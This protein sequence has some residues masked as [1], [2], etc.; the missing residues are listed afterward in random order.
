MTKAGY[1]EP[2]MSRADFSNFV[3]TIMVWNS[4][5]SPDSE[6][7]STATSMDFDSL[8]DIETLAREQGVS[9]NAKFDD[10]LVD[11]WPADQGVDDFL[12]ARERWRREGRN[13]ND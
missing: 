13:S 5:A 7:R 11:F 2:T 8:P 12:T 10:L 1:F 9:S 6:H 3:A 4:F